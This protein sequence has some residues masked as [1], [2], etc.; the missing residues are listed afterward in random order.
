MANRLENSVT[1]THLPDLQGNPFNFNCSCPT[2]TVYSTAY[3]HTQHNNGRNHS[4]VVQ[5]YNH[6]YDSQLK[7]TYTIWTS[8]FRLQRLQGRNRTSILLFGR[9]T[10]RKRA[11]LP[12]LFTI[13]S[14]RRC[15]SLCACTTCKR[16]LLGCCGSGGDGSEARAL[17]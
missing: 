11:T 5:L 9:S 10:R 17:A 16:R 14:S 12:T 2:L 3:G 1:P 13:H 15:G 6:K 7:R 8:P 4:T